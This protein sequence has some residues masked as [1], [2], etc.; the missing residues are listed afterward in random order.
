MTEMSLATIPEYRLTFKTG[1]HVPPLHPV[2]TSVRRRFLE[3][4]GEFLISSKL[5]VFQQTQANFEAASNPADPDDK[6]SRTQK[7]HVL[8]RTG[9]ANCLE[10]FVS[11][12]RDYYNKVVK[13]ACANPEWGI[14]DPPAWARHRIQELLDEKLF[15]PGVSDL[16]A[17][18]RWFRW[19][20]EGLP[21]FDRG[22][23]GFSEPWCGPVWCALHFSI[24]TWTRN[25]CPDR[26]TAERTQK[27]INRA[28]FDF[29]E[30]L[31]NELLVAEDEARIELE[32]NKMQSIVPRPASQGTSASRAPSRARLPVRSSGPLSTFEE[33]VGK[34][35]AQA[36]RECPTKCL[37]QTEILKIAT[38]LD[39][40]KSFSLRDNLERAASHEMAEHNKHYSKAAIKTWTSALRN[41]KFRRAVRK[42]FSRAEEKYKKTTSFVGALSAGTSR[43]TV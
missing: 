28:R 1:A 16:A 5:Q 11:S 9:L 17:V 19:A 30:R 4:T 14:P 29:T 31:K 24:S 20:C 12:G 34:L 8:F 13:I 27:E 25:G 7:A 18:E 36:R 6:N 37:P 33:T 15:L 2:L 23:H 3:E 38:V 39:D 21:D 32:G 22:E 43:T 41:P 26:L 42:R 10:S 35:M 40:D